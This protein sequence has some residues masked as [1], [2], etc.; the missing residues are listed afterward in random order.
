MADVGGGESRV[1]IEGIKKIEVDY[2]KNKDEILF[3][4]KCL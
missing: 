3:S 1:I 4:R 2:E